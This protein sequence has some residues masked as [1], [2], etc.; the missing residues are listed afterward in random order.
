MKIQVRVCRAFCLS[1]PCFS[2]RSLLPPSFLASHP[3]FHFGSLFAFHIT[4]SFLLV[5]LCSHSF[6]VSFH[7]PFRPLPLVVTRL[8]PH[9]QDQL[10]CCGYYSPYVE[11]T[12]SQTCYA[13][14]VLPGYVYPSPHALVLGDRTIAN[15]IS[16]RRELANAHP[17]MQE[18]LLA[19][20]RKD[21]PPLVDRCVCPCPGPA[22]GH[23]Q[24][25]DV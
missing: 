13:R 17:Q 1:L 3:L 5:S 12:V 22:P 10:Q 15:G 11:A 19:M 23:D 8:T 14:S 21:P 25:V 6:F 9:L 20:G 2:P 16:W 24:C 18:T 4:I 7:S